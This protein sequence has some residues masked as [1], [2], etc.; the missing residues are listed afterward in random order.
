MDNH[1]RNST[2]DVLSHILETKNTVL[3]GGFKNNVYT[4][5]YDFILDEWAATNPQNKTINPESKL[6]KCPI[7]PFG[8]WYEKNFDTNITINVLVWYGIFAVA[9]EHIIQHP[10][11]RYENLIKYVDSH[12]NPEAGHYMERSWGAIFYPYPSSCIYYS[13]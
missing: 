9:R 13:S 3:H 12:S 10:I 6:Q 5:V 8:K 11:E 7:R 1:K 2:N 4:D